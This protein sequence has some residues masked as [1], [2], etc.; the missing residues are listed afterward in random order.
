[1]LKCKDCRRFTWASYCNAAFEERKECPSHGDETACA[2]YP[3]RRQ[4]A[5]E[6]EVAELSR[7]ITAEW[8]D[9]EKQKPVHGDSVL[10]I[11]TDGKME[12]YQYS[13]EWS[14]CL[15]QYDGNI[16]TFNITHW[17]PLPKPPSDIKMRDTL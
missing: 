11:D 3:E 8:F 14:S 15:M 10:G 7:R 6:R 9:F 2:L 5:Q 13:D 12:V 4:M 1:M 17:M 16:K